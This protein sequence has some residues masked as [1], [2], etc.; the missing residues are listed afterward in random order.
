MKRAC[1]NLTHK[2]MTNS[3]QHV[4]PIKLK[5][6]HMK[7][8]TVILLLVLI[9]VQCN[10]GEELMISKNNLGVIN[11]N[12]TIAEL[13]ELFKNDSIVKLPENAPIFYKYRIYSKDGKQLLTLNMDYDRDSIKGIENIKIFDIKYKTDR[14]LSTLS[15]YKDVVNNY[16][17]SKI[18]PSFSSAI[19]F[20]DELNATLALDK[21]DL[22]IDEFDM[23][24]ISKDQIPDMAKIKYIT[25]WF[26]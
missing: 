17:I 16:T 23:R 1:Q 9:F 3:E 12:T 2:G 10:K 5:F 11:K 24:K 26:D 19:V 15:T 25:I 7:R 18:E 6:R 8:I 13:E 4:S 21:A 14:G 20:I 22:K